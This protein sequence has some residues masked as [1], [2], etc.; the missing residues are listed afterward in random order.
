MPTHPK[1]SDWK[2]STPQE[3][4]VEARFEHKCEQ[5]AW[6]QLTEME[7]NTHA[8]GNFGIAVSGNESHGDTARKTL[9][10]SP[11]HDYKAARR[12]Y[13]LDTRDKLSELDY[14]K[15]YHYRL[16]HQKVARKYG[17]LVP[18]KGVIAD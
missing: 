14:G 7:A 12:Q 2:R 8:Q 5:C 10:K 11:Q 3:E 13:L 6:R 1:G 17:K 15:W 9:A 4:Q 18:K 16:R